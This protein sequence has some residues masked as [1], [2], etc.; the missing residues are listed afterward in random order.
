MAGKYPFER[1]S[2]DG[3]QTLVLAQEEAERAGSS[4]I[5]TEHLLLGLLRLRTGSAHRA[6]KRLGV[7]ALS[8]RRALE[9]LPRPDQPPTGQIIP[10]SRVKRVIEVAFNESRRMKSSHVESGHLLIGVAMEGEG[11]AALVLKDRGVTAQMVVAA[12]A[13]ETA[14]D[15]PGNDPPDLRI[16]GRN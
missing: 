1:F 13:G 8:V 2:E 6:L 12:V 4:Y 5:G 3:K 14:S 11:I 9:S 15:E 10:T 7:D 16:Y